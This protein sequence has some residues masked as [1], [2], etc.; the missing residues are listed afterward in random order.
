MITKMLVSML[1][2]GAVLVGG[3]SLARGLI[4]HVEAMN[5]YR[6]A[7]A[8]LATPSA[9]SSKAT[10]RRIDALTYQMGTEAT[11][12][13]RPPL[14]SKNDTWETLACA[15]SGCKPVVHQKGDAQ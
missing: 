9:L 15:E 10:S 2:V 4:A 13:A 7:L 1:F 6:V 14:P 11:A 12:L 3:Q 8:D 5:H